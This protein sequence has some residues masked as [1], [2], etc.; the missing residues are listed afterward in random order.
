VNQLRLGF[1]SAGGGEWSFECSGQRL[2]DGEREVEALQP[3]F[4]QLGL[5]AL[6]S[7]FRFAIF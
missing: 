2:H 3:K 4:R 5:I 6:I 1:L 7:S